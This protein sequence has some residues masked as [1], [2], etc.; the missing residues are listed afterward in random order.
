MNLL[1]NL[2]C[3]LN[4][5]F[6]RGFLSCSLADTEKSA[7]SRDTK[8]AVSKNRQKNLRIFQTK[9]FAQEVP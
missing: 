5:F 2:I 7:P 3:L 8:Q 1:P 4:S 6:S 9:Q